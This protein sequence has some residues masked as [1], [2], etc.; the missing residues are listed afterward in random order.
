[1][2]RLRVRAER[3]LTP[4]ER[5][6]RHRLKLTRQ[7]ELR[8]E[9]RLPRRLVVAIDKVATV[10]SHSRGEELALLVTEALVSRTKRA[11]DG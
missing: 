2:S 5:K 6:L 4:K 3:R 10:S 8:V 1:M 7:G 11:T 9:L